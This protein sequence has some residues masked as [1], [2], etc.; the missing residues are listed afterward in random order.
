MRLLFVSGL[1][2]SSNQVGRQLS[3]EHDVTVIQSHPGT[4]AEILAAIA[5]AAPDLLFVDRDLPGS[6]GISA[7]QEVARARRGPMPPVIILSDVHHAGDVTRAVKAGVRGYLTGNQET[8]TVNA[9]ITA[10][11]SGA[12]WLSPSAA[13]ELLDELHKVTSRPAAALRHASLTERERSVIR[14]IAQGRSNVEVAQ[15]LGVSVSTIKG[16]VSRMLAK[17]HL[18][19]RAQL[20]VVARDLDII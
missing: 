19:R 3:R 17:L 4:V 7:V 15:E 13:G 6:D 5:R 20:A 11:V 9:A 16:H 1:S 2:V 12:A 18:R 8:W 10:V 14:L